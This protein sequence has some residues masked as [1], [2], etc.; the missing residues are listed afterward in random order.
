M[1]SHD[2]WLEFEQG[3]TRVEIVC[4]MNV[5]SDDI[6]K[7]NM[8]PPAAIF[9]LWS[10]EITN[11]IDSLLEEVLHK[12]RADPLVHHE[13]AIHTT[14][15]IG[16][17]IPTWFG[18]DFFPCKLIEKQKGKQTTCIIIQTTCTIGCFTNQSIFNSFIFLCC[19]ALW[20]FHTRPE[21]SENLEG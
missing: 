19:F 16:S 14:L 9:I 6:N 4:D 12:P 11:C 2:N 21:D 17:V 5:V 10:V 13:S 3:D 8:I 7:W 1:K 18:H 20:L 15:E